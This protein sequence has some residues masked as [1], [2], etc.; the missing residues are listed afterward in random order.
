MEQEYLIHHGIKGQKWGVR[1]FQ[2]AD[3]TLTAA[4]KKHYALEGVPR[5]TRRNAK[6]DAKESATAKMYYGEGAGTRRK[7]INTVVN[8]RSKDAAYKKAYDYYYEQQD[9]AKVGAKARTQR[10]TRDA[11]KTTTK[12]ARGL[13]NIANGNSR[14]A[15]TLALS[16]AAAYGIARKTGADKVVAQYANMAIDKLI[17]KAKPIKLNL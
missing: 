6:N 3:G 16:I 8:Q 7:R 1:R 2:N 10:K 13:I 4:G 9:M 5:S 15:S 14:F 12:T 11:A 17:N